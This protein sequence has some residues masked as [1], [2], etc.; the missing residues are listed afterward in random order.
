MTGA[1]SENHLWKGFQFTIIS[2]NKTEKKLT[3]SSLLHSLGKSLAST[4]VKLDQWPIITPQWSDFYEAILGH[5]E[6][7]SLLS[8]IC[9]ALKGEILLGDF[10]CNG[11]IYF[12]VQFG[13]ISAKQISDAKSDTA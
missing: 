9:T 12:M 4:G 2:S 13:S 3:G 1:T 5:T 6:K 11:N 7:A 8:D 10:F